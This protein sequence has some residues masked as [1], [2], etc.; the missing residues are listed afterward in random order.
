[1]TACVRCTSA[2]EDGDLRC[3]ICA[4]VVPAPDAAG[5]VDRPRAKVLRC[6]ECNAAIAYCAT[7]GA[8]RCAFCSAVM[9]VEQPADPIETAQKRLPFRIDRLAAEHALHGWLA[10]RGFFAPRQLRDE[11]VLESLVPLCWA[12]W[13][14]NARALVTWT[15]DSD[16]GAKR[17]AWAPHAGQVQLQF[18]SICVPASRGLS[19]DECQRLL[20]YYDLASA[21]PITDDGDAEIETFEAQRSA[22]RHLV[23][24]AIESEARVRVEDFIPGRRFRNVRVACL[25]EGQ[26]TDRVALPAW[27]LAYRYRGQPY[28]AIVHGQR[29]GVVIGRAPIDWRKV[30]LLSGG[31]LAIV[32]AI[33]LAVLLAR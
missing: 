24:R 27:V 13:I 15:A 7:T 25:L 22:A 31:V 14:V 1:M 33:V 20:P 5:D 4:L 8:P 19:H 6:A 30:A 32:A 2:V 11:A 10:T 26:T 17:S 12:G 18:A 23:A 21:R 16:A 29:A 9:H 3:A 28:R